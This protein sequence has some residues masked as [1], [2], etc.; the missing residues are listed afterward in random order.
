MTDVSGG[1]GATLPVALVTGSS[2]G[3]GLAAARALAAE[4]FAVCLNC[5]SENGL[6][7]LQDQ[8]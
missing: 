4:G 1:T 8:A 7:R 5:S 6:G 3:I 2:R